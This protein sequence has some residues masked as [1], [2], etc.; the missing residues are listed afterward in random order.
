MET[1]P[2][3]KRARCNHQSRLLG[4]FHEGAR[5]VSAVAGTSDPKA[6]FHEYGTSEIPSR[7]FMLPAALDS[8]KAIVKI[9]RKQVAAAF[10]R[11][12]TFHELLH[13]LK[14]V[15]RAGREVVDSLGGDDK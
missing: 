7:P 1:H 14:E 4:P 10:A 6:A 12:A 15:Y 5:T 2:Y 13:A 3:T 9:A 11:G 8:E